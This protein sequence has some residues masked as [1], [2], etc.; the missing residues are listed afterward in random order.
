MKI[1]IKLYYNLCVTFFIVTMIMV[2][3]MILGIQQFV[4]DIGIVIL[5]CC[6]C[7]SAAISIYYGR[8]YLYM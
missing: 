8:E 4:G 3:S 2:F 1:N 7:I 6:A 5:M